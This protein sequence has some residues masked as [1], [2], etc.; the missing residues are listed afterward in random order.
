MYL[1]FRSS[2]GMRFDMGC[3]IMLGTV[4]KETLEDCK[5]HVVSTIWK[6]NPEE[7][8]N[9]FFDEDNKPKCATFDYNG[10]KLSAVYVKLPHYE[11]EIFCLVETTD[12]VGNATE[13]VGNEA[14]K[15][16]Y[17]ESGVPLE[18]LHHI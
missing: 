1:I 8:W 7:R 9:H 2:T 10:Y 14:Y 4:D 15:K 17:N 3:L 11:P 5:S 6:L 18:I 13:R 16:Y 12:R